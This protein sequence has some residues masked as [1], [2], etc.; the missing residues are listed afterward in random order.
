MGADN[1][2]YDNPFH[3]TVILGKQH[4]HHPQ[5]HTHL[6]IHNLH[7]PVT[8]IIFHNDL[9]KINTLTLADSSADIRTIQCR[10]THTCTAWVIFYKFVSSLFLQN[11]TGSQYNVSIIHNVQFVCKP[12]WSTQSSK[13]SNETLK[14]EHGVLQTGTQARRHT[15]NVGFSN[16]SKVMPI[17][18]VSSTN[19]HNREH[20]CGLLSCHTN[21]TDLKSGSTY[22]NY[23]CQILV[24]LHIFGLKT[25]QIWCPTLPVNE[26]ASSVAVVM[27]MIK[28]I[29]KVNPWNT[30][31]KFQFNYT[32]LVW[33]WSYMYILEHRCQLSWSWM[34]KGLG[35]IRTFCTHTTNKSY[36][37]KSNKSF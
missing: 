6:A 16:D 12:W 4:Q 20:S 14:V 11:C 36:T 9:I 18:Y 1:V 21:L 19:Q 29:L 22:T 13:R 15:Y 30:S 35:Y 32:F 26:L 23:Q 27:N 8:V 5:S 25:C 3:S 7:I 10:P 34:W 31:V 37:A 17:G 24:Q 33:I 2:D 28:V